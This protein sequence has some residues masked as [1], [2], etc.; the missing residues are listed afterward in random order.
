MRSK[1]LPL[2]SSI[3]KRH[4]SKF[5]PVGFQ[6]SNFFL[7]TKFAPENLGLNITGCIGVATTSKLWERSPDQWRVKSVSAGY[8]QVQSLRE[9][10]EG[11][12][13]GPPSAAGAK[14][15][16]EKRDPALA[17]DFRL[18]YFEHQRGGGTPNFQCSYCLLPA[19][20]SSL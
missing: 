14:R 16:P 1:F 13:R 10:L 20:S 11:P 6:R 17:K 7:T 9:R 15:S 3:L 19:F 5:A 12:R 8:R 4:G 18:T 2:E